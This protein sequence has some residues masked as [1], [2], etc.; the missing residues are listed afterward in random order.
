VIG[1][2]F[3]WPICPSPFTDVRLARSTVRIGAALSDNDDLLAEIVAINQAV[4]RALIGLASLA[5]EEGRRDEYVAALLE[6]GLR[7]LGSTKFT[8][9]ESRRSVS[10]RR[11]GLATPTSSFRST[12]G[13]DRDLPRRFAAKPFAGITR[14]PSDT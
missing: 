9:M 12:R 4:T 6:N 13:N 3:S 14:R 11:R 2:R 8:G 10:W 1:L 5:G 7:D